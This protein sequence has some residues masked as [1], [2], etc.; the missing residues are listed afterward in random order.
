MEREAKAAV[1]AA[2]KDAESR[3][4]LTALRSENERLKREVEA[5]KEASE[6]NKQAAV[7]RATQKM[8]EN[9]LNRYKD[10]LR[11]GASLSRGGMAVNLASSTPD[12]AAA[13]GSSPGLFS[14]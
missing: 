8:A 14:V 7:L 11:D 12:S 2:S 9:M 10:G 6:A 3:A 13:A 4:E 1:A 5:V